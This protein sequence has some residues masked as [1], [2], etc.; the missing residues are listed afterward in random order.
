MAKKAKNIENRLRST[1]HVAQ[2]AT[3]H[4]EQVTSSLAALA[5]EVQGSTTIAT[6]D[7]FEIVIDFLTAALKHA[8]TKL[9]TTELA[10]VAEKADDVGLREARDEHEIITR[11]SCIRVK[12]MI[13]DALGDNA[14]A[15]YG[16][17]GPTPRGARDVLTHA[18][19]VVE[20]L[21]KKP[22]QKTVEGVTY[23]SAAIA[24]GLATKAA[25]LAQALGDVDREEQELRDKLGLRDKALG[26]WTDTYQGGA[27][28]LVGLFRLA[29]RKDLAEAVRPTQKT[30]SGEEIAP[31][32]GQ[33]PPAPPIEPP[34]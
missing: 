17:E 24:T 6:R 21:Q 20:L 30:V 29:G 28:A 34:P 7:V 15:V 31:E 19:T 16:L 25:T 10:V 13:T 3:V 23:D 12:S 9:D 11:N 33:V 4:R 2:A 27:D 8:G 26:T 22:F 14:L 1:E 5:V 32:V 18:R